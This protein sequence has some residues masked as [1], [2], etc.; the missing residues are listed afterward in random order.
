MLVDGI[1]IDDALRRRK[2]KAIKEAS[3]AAMCIQFPASLAFMAG[4]MALVIVALDSGFASRSPG[5]CHL[6]V[7]VPGDGGQ[8]PD[9]Q[10]A[11]GNEPRRL[12][13]GDGAVPEAC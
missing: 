10:D 13:E 7:L 3:F 5:D 4:M 11:R 12:R 1:E 2:N 9:T 8:D 6:V